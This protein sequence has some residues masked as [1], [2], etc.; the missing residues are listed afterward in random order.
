MAKASEKPVDAVLRRCE[1]CEWQGAV[2]EEAGAD[3]D[4][5]WCHG[6]TR[7]AATLARSTRAVAGEKNPHAAALGRLG[8]LKGGRARARALS[9]A[10]R[11]RIASQAAKARWARKKREK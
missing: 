11:R 5:P 10:R 2:I 9:P 8:G 7:R 3:P 1:V 6:P 4:C